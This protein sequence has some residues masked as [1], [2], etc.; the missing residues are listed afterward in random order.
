M[1]EIKQG[2]NIDL[3][4][5]PKAEAP[6][7]LAAVAPN[8]EVEAPNAGCAAVIAQACASRAQSER[9]ISTRTA[10]APNAGAAAPKAGLAP[11]GEAA[12]MQ[13]RAG[14]IIRPLRLSRGLSHLRLAE[15][16]R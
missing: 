11:K 14:L 13:V 15:S 1:C 7:G 3:S 9:Q 6:K 16:G 4:P 2:N 5:T 12:C 10:V 8:V